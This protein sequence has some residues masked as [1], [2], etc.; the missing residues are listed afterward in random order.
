MRNYFNKLKQDDQGLLEA[1]AMLNPRDG[2][3]TAGLN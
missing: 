3:A 1:A 2:I